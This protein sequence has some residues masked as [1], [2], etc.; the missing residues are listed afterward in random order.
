MALHNPKTPLNIGHVLRAAGCYDA[1]LIVIAGERGHTAIKSIATDT[2]KAWRHTPT[3]CV[4]DVLDALPIG[5]VP[6]AVDLVPEAHSLITF[7]HPERGFYIFG[8]EDGT[9]EESLTERC[10]VK[11][12]I[13]TR[14]CM[15]LSAAVN[16]VLYD[17]LA[18]AQQRKDSSYP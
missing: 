17:R 1:D 8:P 2:Q 9:L 14:A 12:M 16:V 18:K 6:I 5:A 3:L 11:L 13:P 7:V 15:N 4:P 10:A